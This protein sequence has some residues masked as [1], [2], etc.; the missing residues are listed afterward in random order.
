MVKLPAETATVPALP[1]AK[2]LELISPPL[3]IEAWPA[4]VTCTEPA[5]PVE[6]R[7]ALLAIPVKYDEPFPSM[8][9]APAETVT[10]PALPDALVPEMI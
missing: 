5:F 6:P 7:F 1:D 3:T 10:D 9:K 4:T 2:V 8:A